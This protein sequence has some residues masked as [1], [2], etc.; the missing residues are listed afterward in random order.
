MYKLL[1]RANMSPRPPQVILVE[2]S[3]Q[4]IQAVLPIEP[5]RF[6]AI[7]LETSGVRPEFGDHIVGIGFADE[8]GCCYVDF[9]GAAPEI[10]EYVRQVLQTSR[11][12]AFNVKF[13]SAF[14]QQFTRQRLDWEGCSYG[15]FAYMAN[16]DSNGWNLET[17]QR[18][19]L[20]WV[21]SNKTARDQAL[22][23]YGL[24]KATM[25]KLPPHLLG[26]YCA[27]DADAAWQLWHLLVN[28]CR[29]T[30]LDQLLA[31]HKR[32]FMTEVRLFMQQQLR[33]LL[34]DREMLA[35][36]HTDLLQRIDQAMQTFLQHP[37]TAPHIAAYN[38]QVHKA[39]SAAEPPR[40]K[41]DGTQSARWEQWRDREARWMEDSSFNPNSKQQLG[42]LFYEAAFSVVRETREHVTVRVDG[43]DYEVE[44]T[45]TGQRSVKKQILPL[46]GEAG[47]ALM[48]FNKLS[49]EEGYVRAALALLEI[50]E[51]LHPE[52]NIVGTVTGRPAGGADD[53]D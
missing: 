33:G 22:Q 46:F 29:A 38:A 3:L 11:L 50:S 27:A 18:E 51:I 9:R 34:G 7:D 21:D 25:S 17:A 41:K 37:Q 36:Y 32:E 1:T 23:E 39:W 49:K 30:K 16:A 28:T 48:A 15:L 47:A 4:T 52:M 45:E 43:K 10:L 20:G 40:T 13:D 42:W 8:A 24:T 53:G 35:A 12:T 26:P 2:P 44:K 31:F 14:L 5:G 19:V 6:R